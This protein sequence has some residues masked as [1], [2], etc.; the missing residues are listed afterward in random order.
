MTGF[1]SL[2]DQPAGELHPRQLASVFTAKLQ[3]TFSK[4]VLPQITTFS[5]RIYIYMVLQSDGY[6]KA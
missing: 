5:F 2:P 1:L 6:F 4:K 3:R